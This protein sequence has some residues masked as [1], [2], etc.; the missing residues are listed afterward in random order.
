M[1]Q[2]LTFLS[3]TSRLHGVAQAWVRGLGFGGLGAAS[4]DVAG[5]ADIAIAQRLA[6]RLRTP[7]SRAPRPPT[8]WRSTIQVQSR[9]PIRRPPSSQLGSG[10]AGSG[11]FRRPPKASPAPASWLVIERSE[12]GRGSR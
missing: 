10:G 7:G 4:A 6:P 8:L 3:S 11:C 9:Q 1:S 5:E 2:T 12:V